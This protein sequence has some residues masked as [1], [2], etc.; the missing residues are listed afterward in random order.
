MGGAGGGAQPGAAGDGGTSGNHNGG[1]GADGLDGFVGGDANANG[2]GGGGGGGGGFN[3]NGGGAASIDT[4]TGLSG[5]AGGDGGNGGNSGAD[6]PGGGGGGGGGGGYGAIITG[7]GAAGDSTN[8]SGIEITGG[9]GG[10]GGAGGDSSSSF[11]GG[12]GGSGGYGGVGVLF[13]ASGATFTNLGTITGGNG[14][15]RGAGG[16][17]SSIGAPGSAGLG[18]AGIVG[19]GLTVIDSGSI[20]GGLADGGSGAQADAIVFTGGANTLTLQSGWGL[21]GNIDIF[22]G[23]LTFDQSIAVTLLDP[24]Q[25]PILITGNGSVIQNGT[26]DLTLTGANTYSGGTTIQSGTLALSGSGDISNSSGVNITSASGTFDISGLG[27]GTSIASLAGVGHSSVVLGGNTLTVSNAAGTFN[28]IIS[29]AGALTVGAGTLLLAA[30]NTYTGGT[31]IASGATLKLGN[32]GATGNV[33]GDIIDDGILTLKHSS[34][35]MTLGGVISGT[36]SLSLQAP[37]DTTNTTNIPHSYKVVLTGTDTYNGETVV[38]LNGGGNGT[39]TLALSGTGSISNSSGVNIAAAADTFDISALTTGG[40]SIVSLAGVTGS[41]V[42]LGS[43]TLTLSNAADSFGG[44]IGGTGGLTLHAGTET[45]AGTSTYSGATTIEGGTLTITGS[46]ANSAVTVQNG[47]TLAG[48]GTTSAVTL[49]SGGTVS[50]GGAGAAGLLTTGNLAFSSG[51]IFAEE[52]GGTTVGSEYDQVHVN[53]AIDLTGAILSVAVLNSFDPSGLSSFEIINNDGTDQVIGTFAGL[54]QG[55]VFDVHGVSYVISYT[56]GDGNDVVITASAPV[57]GADGQIGSMTAVPNVIVADAD[58]QS[59]TAILGSTANPA[60]YW[61]ESI[62]D[63]S[64]GVTP[65]DPANGVFPASALG[66]GAQVGYANNGAGLSQDIGVLTN[67]VYTVGLD[68]YGR[69]DGGLAPADYKVELLV[70]GHDL[71]QTGIGPGPG[72]TDHANLTFDLT[73]IALNGQDA[74]L[75]VSNPTP[76]TDPTTQID[77]DNVTVTSNTLDFKGLAVSDIAGDNL[78]MTASVTHGTLAPLGDGAGLTVIDGDGSDGSLSV[79]GSTTAIQNALNAGLAYTPTNSSVENLTVAV[80]DGHVT[81][82]VNYVFSPTGAA[83]TLAGTSANDIMLGSAAA[84][85]FAFNPN[86]GHDTVANYTPGTDQ[87]NFDHTDFADVAAIMAA[88]SDVNGN[89][90]ITHGADTVTL[91]GVDTATVH[92]HQNDFHIV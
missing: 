13:T 86:F 65:T 15:T 68:F 40:T 28:G 47:G 36:G 75:V 51:S 12:Y 82:G 24:N 38:G 50:A 78:T 84:D 34:G 18:G 77:F 30:D 83:A 26:G 90:V 19:A 85:T 25:N 9:A 87:F 16:S 14:G 17:G 37:S 21:G 80:N 60:P 57:L 52:L 53:G 58:F 73:G 71:V 59:P 35:T 56:G 79:S 43:N 49:L 31:T 63:G 23:S 10:A 48:T 69:S 74:T 8:N 54:A 27:A 66:S 33:V 81:T 20:A 46:I 44:V 61:I 3:G 11:R 88:T 70:N 76:T 41:S 62:S 72:V 39:V 4:T 64:T 89:A 22:D 55:A 7:S 32:N 29:G 67:S 6:Q 92:Q 2:P 91:V 1:A 5:G 42:L 45:L